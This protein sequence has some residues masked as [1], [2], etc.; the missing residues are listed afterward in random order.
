MYEQ[1]SPKR[2]S[3][4]VREIGTS[5]ITVV[6]TCHLEAEKKIERALFSRPTDEYAL[7]LA[8]G[9]QVICRD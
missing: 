6:A 8:A 4:V 9:G 3:A 5:F 2:Y 7:W 1:Y